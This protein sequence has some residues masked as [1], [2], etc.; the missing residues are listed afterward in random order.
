MEEFHFFEVGEKWGFFVFE[1]R[2]ALKASQYSFETL[3]NSPQ[4]R[5]E[6]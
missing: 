2:I 1:S 3:E 5:N 4:T 6:S